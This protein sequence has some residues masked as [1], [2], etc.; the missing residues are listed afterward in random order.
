MKLALLLLT[1]ACGF[2][3]SASLGDLTVR[4]LSVEGA[5]ADLAV[6]IDN[7]WPVG[8]TANAKWAL[9]VNEQAVASGASTA[10]EV[11][12]RDRSTVVV[13]IAWK[14]SDLWRAAGHVGEAVPYQAE[15]V[16]EG[17]HAFGAWSLP[18]SIE[19]TLPALSIPK[20][21]LLGWRIDEV[22]P[23]RIAWTVS[24]GVRGPLPLTALHWSVTLGG[25]VIAH[26]GL[27]A[28]SGVVEVP[29]VIELAALPGAAMN[30]LEAG[31]SLAVDGAID[32]PIGRLPLQYSLDWRPMAP[33]G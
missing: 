4:E 23:W 30:A 17:E 29:V 15:L 5:R 6:T 8:A 20:V 27:S 11:A 22:S 21:D 9:T 31:M 10:L 33:G 1:P 3:P 14:W 13:P 16:L 18:L 2:A 12:S 25:A 24:V 19:G 28:A 32:T 26:G 7:P